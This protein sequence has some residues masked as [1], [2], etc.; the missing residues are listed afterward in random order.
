MFRRKGVATFVD[1]RKG[2]SCHAPDSAENKPTSGNGTPIPL[3]IIPSV[4]LL[5]QVI[6]QPLMLLATWEPCFLSR[7]V[8]RGCVS[9][10]K[11]QF[12][13]EKCSQRTF[14]FVFQGRKETSTTPSTVHTLTQYTHADA[15]A[16]AHTHTRRHW[17]LHTLTLHDT[18]RLSHTHV[19]IYILAHTCTL[20]HLWMY[21]LP[22]C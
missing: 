18:H 15:L 21:P 11:C 17:H 12:S 3:A 13:L 10:Q 4:V 2:S 1:S 7:R 16:H 6:G 8:P 9:K 22:I 20:N 14:A 19:Y 5:Q